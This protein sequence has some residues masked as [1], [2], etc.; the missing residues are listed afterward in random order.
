MK[1]FIASHKTNLFLKPGEVI[2]SA[3][4]ILVRTILGS[5]V[6]ITMFSQQRQVGAI[7]HAMLPS[8]RERESSPLYV[9]TAIRCIYQK[10][11]EYDAQDDLV[12][13]MFGGAQ[14]LACTD[15]RITYSVGEQNIMQAQE[16]LNSLGLDAII[17]DVGGSSGRKL[18]FSIK[19]G[20][21]YLH[22]LHTRNRGQL[23]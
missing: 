4:P 13:K 14:I 12:V 21:V 18:L 10:M 5:C 11:V 8:P 16:T 7:C 23:H 15:I 2:I 1:H 22:R 6:A 3:S 20:D 17:A 19:T 9:D